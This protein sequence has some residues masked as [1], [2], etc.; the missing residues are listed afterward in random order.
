MNGV[1]LSLDHGYPARVIVP[2]RAR[3]PQ[4]Q[5]GPSMTVPGGLS[6]ARFRSLYGASPLHLLAVIA[7][8][9]IAGYGFLRIFDSPSALEHDALLRRRRPRSTT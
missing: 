5:V 3:R 8:F 2:A 7:S 1:D 9:A 6:V 4:H